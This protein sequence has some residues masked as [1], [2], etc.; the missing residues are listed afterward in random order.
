VERE[1][2]SVSDVGNI[3]ELIIGW[4]SLV[5]DAKSYQIIWA[6]PGVVGIFAREL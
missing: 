3:A 1:F 6:K 4:K 2:E 5:G